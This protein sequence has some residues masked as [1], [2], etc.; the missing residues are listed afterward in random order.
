MLKKTIKYTD[1][2]GVERIEDFYFNLTQAE[3]TE[4]ELTTSGGYA[5]KL[6][7]IVKAQD[8]PT[9]IKV[10]K[11]LILTSY[12]EKSDDG[13]R[14]VKNKELSDNFTQTEAYSTLFMELASNADA[15]GEFVNG[16][17]PAHVDI[18]AIK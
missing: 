11:E 2:N 9:I 16:I 4:M 15:A 17:I 5:E 13:K 3:L 7:K 18:K 10:F 12:G 1:Y 14:F 8:T 6:D